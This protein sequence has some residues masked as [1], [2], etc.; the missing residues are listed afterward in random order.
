MIYSVQSG[1][2]LYKIANRFGTTVQRLVELNDIEDPD[3]LEIGQRL[4]I[5]DRTEIEVEPRNFA[6]EVVNNL[7]LIFFTDESSYQPGEL[8][9][10]TLVKVNIGNNPIEL[11]YNTSQRIDFIARRF[12]QQVW[13]WSENRNFA[14]VLE[15]VKLNPDEAAAYQ[16]SWKQR[17]NEG[18]QIK[19]G[20]Y[21]IRG[22]NVA[23]E[24]DNKK[25]TIAL[26]IE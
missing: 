9:N 21:Q 5:P 18:Q 14:Q 6:Y 23:D 3:S 2:T 8:I 20:I 15:G 11:S 17:S 25:L 22:W 26:R 13:Q 19:S 4:L 10:L 24:I 1:D 7:L 12:E 16:E